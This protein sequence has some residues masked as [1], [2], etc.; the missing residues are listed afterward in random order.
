MTSYRSDVITFAV[1]FRCYRAVIDRITE[2]S[3]ISDIMGFFERIRRLR[4]G[5]AGRSVSGVEEKRSDS[6]AHGT[7][8]TVHDVHVERIVLSVTQRN[9]P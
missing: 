2:F 6:A 1:G 5:V 4:S 7:F 8:F 3:L 9:F